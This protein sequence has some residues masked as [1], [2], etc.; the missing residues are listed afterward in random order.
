MQVD[1]RHR[2][3]TVGAGAQLIDV[4]AALAAHGLTIPAGSCPS[5]GIAGHALGGGMGLAGRQ[6]GLTADNL[7]SAQIV[8]ADGHLRTASGKSN[9]D[10]YWAL[11][12]GGGGNFG[13]ARACASGPTRSRGPSRRSSCRGPGLTRRTRSPRG[14]PGLRTRARSSPRSFTSPAVA[15]SPP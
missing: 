9:P 1:S 12:G 8:T 14:R 10:L 4:Y 7:L 2:I 13:V 6:F 15:E 11:R 3:V 5:V